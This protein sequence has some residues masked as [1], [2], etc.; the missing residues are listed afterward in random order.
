[1]ILT[2]AVTLTGLVGCEI[3]M[4]G[5][6][7]TVEDI[8]YQPSSYW[9]GSE[10]IPSYQW[11]PKIIVSLLPQNSEPDKRY[12]VE[13]YQRG[14]LRL[15]Q[16]VQFTK[17]QINYGQIVTIEFELTKEDVAGGVEPINETYE[18]KIK[19]LR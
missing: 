11:P 7:A 6:I 2:L 13:L 9:I 18:V 3:S 8:S 10:N 17:T 4:G 16:I 5:D 1:M 14:K 19:K 12:T 15:T